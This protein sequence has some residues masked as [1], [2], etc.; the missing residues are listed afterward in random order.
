MEYL[1]ITDIRDEFGDEIADMTDAVV[2]RRLDRLTEYLEDVL[3]HTF[4]RALIAR[5][6][7]P[8]HTVEVTADA[9]VIGSDTYAFADYP[10]LGTLVDAVNGAGKAYS[11]ERLHQV[12]P[13][14]PSTL[15]RR[16]AAVGIGGGY[17]KRAVLDITAMYVR[18]SGDGSTHLFLPLDARSIQAV[19]EDGV[20]LTD[21]QYRFV[22]GDSWITRVDGRWSTR[23]AGNI[24]V[25]FVPELWGWVP[26]P[27][28]SALL[29]AFAAATGRTP[30]ISES[31]GGAYSYRR[32][33]QRTWA[34]DWRD[35]LG[36]AGVARYVVRYHP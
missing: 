15:L 24:V 9:L 3:G 13:E 21:N 33:E 18:M 30:I 4:G 35:I 11:I 1:T 36:G 22:P 5:S 23:Q 25:I 19:T 26:G 34:Q 16:T 10:N 27:I 31:F 20:Q 17:E 2:A 32:A 28:R 14:T 6:D 8:T 29:E 7:D 12:H